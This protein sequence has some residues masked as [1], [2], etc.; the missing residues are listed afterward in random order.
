M[1]RLSNILGVAVVLAIALVFVISFQPGGGSPTQGPG[2]TNAVEVRGSG[3]PSTEF[4]AAYRLLAPPNADAARLRAMG[5]RRL[6]AEGLYE[7]WLLNE[8]AKRLGITVSDEDINAE[9][10][11][12]RAHVSL[13]ADKMRQ[14]GYSLGLSFSPDGELLRFLD[15]RNRQT[16]K[17]DQ[18]RYERDVRAR[19][20]LSPSDY[21]EF[22]K[23]E[24]IASRMRDLIRSRVR[25]SEAEAFEDYS[26]DKSTRTID[27]IR[28]DRRF[29]TDLFVD[30]SDKAVQAW[31]DRNKEEVDKLWEGRKSQFL[32]EC[33]VTRHVLARVKSSE[34]AADKAAAKTKIDSAQEAL[35][36]GEDFASVA[37]RL[38]D[39]PGSAER[40]GDLGCVT[41][42]KMVKPFE[43]KVF[44]MNEGEV[45]E[46]V[47]TDFGYHIIKVE[48]I[49][50]E[51]EAEKVGRLIT[52]RDLYLRQESERLAAEAAKQ[53]LAAVAGGKTMQEA[54]DAYLATLPA[55]QQAAG[56]KK[57]AKKD[58]KAANKPTD[59]AADKTAA[60]KDGEKKDG[61]KKDADKT[62]AAAAGADEATKEGA[63]ENE[64]VTAATH[65]HR[66]TVETSLP[67]NA[68]GEPIPSAQPGTDVARIAFELA[69]PGDVPK[70]VV[71]LDNGYAVIQLKDVKAVNQEQWEKEREPFMATMRTAKQND[72]LVGYIRRLRSTLGSE[73]K[74]DTSLINE[75]KES[76][77][78]STEPPITDEG[79]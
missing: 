26:R 12:G 53:V 17:F 11:S 37:R 13:P 25:V 56:E 71:P 23:K 72:A 43:D 66:P 73:V 67:F 1:K 58:V 18:K 63:K 46:P 42:G 7:R 29:F 27:T 59:K 52:A 62:D 10:V 75:P 20:K 31:A 16:K 5:L 6:T 4:W 44:A 9:L 30:S 22:Q 54:L 79:E 77:S 28:F 8:D 24:I 76:S 49:A 51:A 68:T 57:D 70:D 61:E 74:Y 60:A 21:R 14:V 55:P 32:P 48:K 39:D 38:S 40:G 34:D 15:V 36:K 65:P 41:K 69:K 45:S 3:I 33:R 19:T 64:P 50:K 47:E 35:K 2:I 78:E